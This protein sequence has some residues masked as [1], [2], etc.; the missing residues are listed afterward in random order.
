MPNLGNSALTPKNQI[1][2]YNMGINSKNSIKNIYFFIW[3]KQ[4]TPTFYN[5]FLRKGPSY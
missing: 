5:I 1:T 4:S 2:L 3:Q